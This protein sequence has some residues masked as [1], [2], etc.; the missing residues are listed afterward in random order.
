ML[1]RCVFGSVVLFA[2]IGCAPVVWSDSSLPYEFF[3][4]D[5]TLSATRNDRDDGSNLYPWDVKESTDS[6]SGLVQIIISN[7]CGFAEYVYRGVSLEVFREFLKSDLEEIPQETIVA[8]GTIGEWCRLAAHIYEHETLLTVRSWKGD[9]YIVDA[10]EVYFDNSDDAYVVDEYFIDEWKL[11]DLVKAIPDPGSQNS[12]WQV[13]GM[14]PREREMYERDGYKRFGDYYCAVNGI[15]VQD[16]ATR[17][18]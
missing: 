4:V 9:L 11:G 3:V 15:Y 14:A 13:T 12:C 16:F 17:L 1:K 18:D 5:E 2:F 7:N 10:T 6:E 8:T